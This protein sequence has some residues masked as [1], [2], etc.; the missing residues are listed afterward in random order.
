MNQPLSVTTPGMQRAAE[1]FR[2]ALA[3][4]RRTQSGMQT[5]ISTLGVAWTG[6]A[7][8][9]FNRSLNAWSAEYANIL[10]QLERILGALEGSKATY[11]KT[12]AAATD[13]ASS[14]MRGLPI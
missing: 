13:A 14:A 11:A 5:Q 12:E 6:E 2:A 9:R 10:R 4:S 8:T 1:D 7:A 3:T